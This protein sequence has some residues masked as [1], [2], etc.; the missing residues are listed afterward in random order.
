V[1]KDIDFV[2]FS[3]QDDIWQPWKL[4][5]AIAH[6][7]SI[8]QSKPAAYC[9]RQQLV[10]QNAQKLRLSPA[11]KYGPSFANALVENIMTGC[12]VVL[13]RDALNLAQKQNIPDVKFHDWWL[14]LF[15]SGVG[16]YVYFDP[17][18]G[19]LY[20]QHGGNVAGSP[21]SRVENFKARLKRQFLGQS[22]NL[23]TLNLA[24]AAQFSPLLTAHNRQLLQDFTQARKGTMRQRISFLIQNPVYRQTK[25]DSAIMRLLYLL[26]RL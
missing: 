14:Y 9:S 25:I 18:P 22:K 4:K 7:S 21:V 11:H 24:A 5:R 10:D 17:K 15:I 12:T 19:I 2:A 16:G 1:P 8:S 6:L 23:I 20:R 3:D 13:N 26:N